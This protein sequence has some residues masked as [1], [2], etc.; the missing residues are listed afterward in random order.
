MPP[1]TALGA[2]ALAATVLLGACTSQ[3][4]GAT[5]TTQQ[6]QPLYGVA[7]RVL[8][9]RDDSRPTDPTRDSAGSDATA[10]R[11]LPTHLF[12]PADGDGPFPVVVFS[13]GF[14][15]TPEAYRDLLESWAAAG[16]VVAAPTFPL[17]SQGSAL[18]EA[19]VL[20]QPA[21]VS[22]VLTRVLA[23][24]GSDDDLAG[25]ID[26]AH[27]AVA[28]HSAGAITTLGVLDTCCHDP[29]VTAAVVLAGSLEGLDATAATPGVP[30]LFV[31]GTADD[32]LPLAGGLAA[33][34]AAPAAKAFVEL[35]GGTH[36]APFDDASDPYSAAVRAV[37]TDFLRWTLT[38]DATALADL[39]TDAARPGVTELADDQLTR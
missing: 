5:G 11:E 23:L 18:V 7:D 29:R 39:R 4:D 32:V 19:G 24:A 16:F 2:L 36:S 3:E 9:L 37:S 14:G 31:H 26:A 33:Y 27:V 1:R 22:F 21:D 15:A 13:H 30:T 34:A 17:T 8:D 35:P 6:G 12:W 10:G 20:D 28:G 38:G 25:R